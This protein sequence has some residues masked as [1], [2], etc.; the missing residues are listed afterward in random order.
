MDA[1]K[2]SA[3][4][5][6]ELQACIELIQKEVIEAKKRLLARWVD[7]CF[8][9]VTDQ[10]EKEVANGKGSLVIN[11]GIDADSKASQKV[12]KEVQKQAL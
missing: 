7:R 5:K 1:T 2:L 6:L 12:I 3:V 9:G 8:R 11:L 4:L 10:V